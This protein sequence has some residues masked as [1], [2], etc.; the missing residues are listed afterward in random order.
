MSRRRFGSIRQ[1]PSGSF[2]IR[3]P[4]PDG[5]TRTGEK[6]YRKESDAERALTLIEAKLATGD[7]SDPQRARVKLGDYAAQWITQRAN[8]DAR[9]TEIYTGLLCRFIVPHL[10]NVPLGKIDTAMI[11]EWRATLLASGV[12]ESE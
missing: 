5:K 7:W 11:R 3:Y 6:T 2:Q 10:G 4:G 1:L 9:T 12:G 8:I